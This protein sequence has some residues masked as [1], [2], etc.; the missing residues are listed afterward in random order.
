MSSIELI[1]TT[2]QPALLYSAQASSL[3]IPRLMKHALSTLAQ[4]LQNQG[5]QS[6]GPPFSIYRKLDWNAMEGGRGLLSFFHMAFLI[7]WQL[8]IGIPVPSNTQAGENT[9][10]G[11]VPGGRYLKAIHRGPYHKVRHTY[12]A[13]KE[14]AQNQGLILRDYSMEIYLNDPNQ[15]C[16]CELLTE[17]LVPVQ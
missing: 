7:Q 1:E 11:A 15:V 16:S 12:K 3:G 5:L 13:L 9:Q 2:P 14:A 8:E 4:Q 17:V 10:I 6:S